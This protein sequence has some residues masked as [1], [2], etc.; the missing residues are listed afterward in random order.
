[1]SVVPSVTIT[2]VTPTASAVRK[3]APAFE[4]LLILCRITSKGTS[5][6]ILSDEECFVSGRVAS[7]TIPSGDFMLEMEAKTDS[8]TRVRG[9][10]DSRKVLSNSAP[11]SSREILSV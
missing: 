11:R 10:P 3:I 1:M 9:F 4:G 7:M 8:L 5:S 6:E 2:P